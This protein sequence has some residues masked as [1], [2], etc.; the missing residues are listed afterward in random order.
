MSDIHLTQNEADYLIALNKIRK[1]EDEWEFPDLGGAI[2]IPLSS[3]DGKESFLLDC[4][5]GR[6]D[7]S[8]I[9]YQNRARQTVILVRLDLAGSPHRNP[10]DAEVPCPH[11][12]L[13]REGFGDK[14]AFPIPDSFTD[15]S[16]S[17][18]TLQEF[19]NFC[20]IIQPPILRKGLFS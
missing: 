11:F 16:D 3:I 19:M 13:Y 7:L 1:N 6:I 18:Q 14:W 2:S 4:S 9:K 8:K 10:D 20:N 17:W 15:L 12:H 5:K